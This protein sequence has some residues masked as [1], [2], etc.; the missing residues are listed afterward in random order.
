MNRDWMNRAACRSEDPA[1]FFPEAHGINGKRQ[2]ER[3][4]RICQ[5]CPVRGECSEY[6]QATDSHYGIWAGTAHRSSASGVSS[7][8]PHRKRGKGPGVAA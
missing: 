1:L 4:A 3:A 6:R 2:A 8:G 7:G 5:P